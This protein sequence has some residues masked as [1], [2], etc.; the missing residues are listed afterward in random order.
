MIWIK[1]LTFTHTAF[2]SHQRTFVLEVMGRHCGWVLCSVSIQMRYYTTNKSTSYHI[3]VHTGFSYILGE[4]TLRLWVGLQAI[5][6]QFLCCNLSEILQNIDLLRVPVM[7]PDTYR[8]SG[9]GRYNHLGSIKIT[10]L[11]AGNFTWDGCSW[12]VWSSTKVSHKHT[13]MN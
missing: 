13:Q 1:V 6:L 5:M 8:T 7:S 11:A 3:R 2:L 9:V 10:L 12:K 4:F